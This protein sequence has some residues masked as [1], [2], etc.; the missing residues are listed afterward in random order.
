MAGEGVY[1]APSLAAAE[2]GI[3][4]GTGA[5]VAVEIARTTVMRGDPAGPSD[6]L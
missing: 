6:F 1:D 2:L 3:A 4:M 5:D